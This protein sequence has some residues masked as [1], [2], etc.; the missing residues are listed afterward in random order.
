MRIYANG[1]SVKRNLD[2]AIHLACTINTDAPAEILDGLPGRKVSSFF[3]DLNIILCEQISYNL[4]I[5]EIVKSIPM[6]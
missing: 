6:E 3:I 2:L 4:G 5:R 1:Y